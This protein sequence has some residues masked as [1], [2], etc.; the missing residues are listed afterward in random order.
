MVEET[1]R[2]LIQELRATQQEVSRLLASVAQDQDWQREPAE[3][4]FRLLA[5][6]LAAVERE[7]HIPRIRHIASGIRPHFDGY[8]GSHPDLA[9]HDLLD[10]LADWTCVRTEL[11]ELVADLPVER[12]E[13]AGVQADV[14]DVTVLDLLAQLLE[15][16]QGNARFVQQLIE[17]YYEEILYTA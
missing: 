17:D 13:V 3:W 5:A 11:L 14:G 9:D 15:Q 10:S 6:H 4:S 2:Q 8:A 16:D 7:C 1:R 12:L